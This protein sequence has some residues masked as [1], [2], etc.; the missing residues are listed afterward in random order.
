MEAEDNASGSGRRSAAWRFIRVAICVLVAWIIISYLLLPDWWRGHE[1]RHPALR[2]APRLTVTAA[3]IP[4]DPLNLFVI[5]T[6]EQLVSAMLGAG[7]HPADPITLETSVRI[8]ESSIFHRPYEDAPVSNLFLYGRREDLAFEKPAG[9]DPRERHHVRFWQAGGSPSAWWGAVTFDRCIGFSHDT[10]QITHHIS[11]DIDAERD[12]LMD[13]LLRGTKKERE[14][15]PG[16]QQRE[17]RNGGGDPWT[18]DGR[19]GIMKLGG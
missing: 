16:F 5:D 17:G 14:Y 1:Q 12:R 7:W 6:R 19:L 9:N 10:G 11:P 2:D 3:G 8:A 15:E 13:D 4:G 18:S